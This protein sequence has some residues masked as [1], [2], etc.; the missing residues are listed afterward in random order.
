MCVHQCTTLKFD[1]FIETYKN[2][3]IVLPEAG[4]MQKLEV[5][6]FYLCLAQLS[7]INGN[8]CYLRDWSYQS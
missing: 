1:A 7:R 5:K 8:I 3:A 4:E 2:L 6:S